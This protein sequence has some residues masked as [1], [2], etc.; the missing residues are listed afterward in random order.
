MRAL[1]AFR[2]GGTVLVR[3]LRAFR[4]DKIVFVRARGLPRLG[5]NILIHMVNGNGKRLIGDAHRF[6]KRHAAAY[7]RQLL[8]SRALLR[9]GK[10]AL[11]DV[12]APR[13]FAHRNRP[14]I[15]AAHH[16][17][18]QHG[19]SADVCLEELVRMLLA[20]LRHEL[21]R[22]ADRRGQHADNGSDGWHRGPFV[23]VWQQHHYTARSLTAPSVPK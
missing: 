7:D 17:A 15:A 10:G 4:L 12:D 21:Q 19:R 2:I 14:A 3:E 1:R 16:H 20:A 23:R 22:M 5:G 8:P 6:D 13:L 18:F 11:F 9:P